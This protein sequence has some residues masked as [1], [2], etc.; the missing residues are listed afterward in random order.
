M[1]LVQFPT[2]E[3]HTIKELEQ[4]KIILEELNEYLNE[5]VDTLQKSV[6]SEAKLPQAHK[7]RELEQE[8]L[9]LNEINTF[10]DTQNQEL[11]RS[12]QEY[13]NAFLSYVPPEA[14]NDAIA[15]INKIKKLGEQKSFRPCL[16][17]IVLIDLAGS[18]LA[19]ARL[20]PDE[21]IKRIKQFGGFTME[22]LKKIPARNIQIFLSEIGDAS[23]FLFTNFQ[24]VLNWARIVDEL[25]NAYNQNCIMEGKPE[26]YQMYSRKCIH[27]GEVHFTEESDP[28]ALAI[29][30]IFKIEK[31][32]K[33]GQFGITDAVKQVILPRINSGQLNAKL[34][35]RT[36]L[37]G[38]NYPCRLWDVT[39]VK[40]HKEVIEN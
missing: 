21:N 20:E 12:H 28:I 13:E 19:S 34:I 25:L 27:L 22:A 14:R 32:F 9:L 26:V 6:N 37:P 10:L 36:V 8:K 33:N 18:T 29:N 4:A 39:V 11:A 15:A 16:Y 3:S 7:V 23:L 2:T 5:K 40:S 38:E 31:E 30:Q 1:K 24:D 17:Y 35:T